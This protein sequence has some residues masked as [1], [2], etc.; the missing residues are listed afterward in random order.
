MI[1]QELLR[2]PFWATM[3]P[4][5]RRLVRLSAPLPAEMNPFAE[6]DV[7]IRVAGVP[8]EAQHS[9]WVIAREAILQ[10]IR[11]GY[12][13]QDIAVIE[14]T[15]GNT[16]DAMAQICNALDIRF[17]AVMSSDVPHDKI[18]AIRAIGRRTRV[19][20]RSDADETTVQ[21][22]RRLGAHEGW[23]NPS[24]YDGDWNWRA[25]LEHLAPQLWA[26]QPHISLLFVPSGTMGTSI[27]LCTYVRE[28]VLDTTIV[29]VLCAEEEE[30]PGARTLSSVQKDVRQPWRSFF[31]EKDLQFG[32]RHESFFL[33][34]L[35]WKY[36]MPH[37]GPSSGLAFAGA[38]RFLGKH[39]DAGTLEQF[40]DRET[41]K[42][43]VVVFGPDDCR[44]YR[45]LYFGELKKREISAMTPPADLLS[46]LG[47]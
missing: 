45:P 21:Y 8:G 22:A 10:G 37:L 24:Q 42:I 19:D 23:Y 39:R 12:I 29:P 18:D 3:D 32:M 40:K 7:T 33:S 14:A 36:V 4:T 41:G 34:F 11:L 17:T 2:H 25:H 46:V 5:K 15:S 44:P 9:K 30:V 47:R 13:D 26:Q 28:K 35:S 31:Q 1:N 27:G 16:G 6:N 43:E 20:V 38:L